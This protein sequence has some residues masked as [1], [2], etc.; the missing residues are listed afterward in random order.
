[1]ARKNVYGVPY[2]PH[3]RRPEHP[4]DLPRVVVEPMSSHNVCAETHTTL[5]LNHS[6]DKE[7]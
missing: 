3:G 5:L 6:P 2:L 1:M 4:C 7:P